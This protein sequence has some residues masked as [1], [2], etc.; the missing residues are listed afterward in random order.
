VPVWTRARRALLIA[1]TIWLVLGW[2]AFL[3]IDLFD[4]GGS[5]ALIAGLEQPQTYFHLYGEA[6]PTEWLQWACLGF[7]AVAAGV[8]AGRLLERHP[9]AGVTWA[10]FAAGMAVLLIEDAGNP[11][12]RVA[13]YGERLAGPAAG[14]VA[15]LA[16]YALVA[17]LPVLAAIR[18]R[19]YLLRFAPGHRYLLAGYAAYAVAAGASATRSLWY[20]RAGD[21]LF[22]DRLLPLT[23]EGVDRSSFFALDHLVEESVELV[24]AALLLAGALTA[25]EHLL[26]PAARHA[27]ATRVDLVGARRTVDEGGNF[28]RG[29]RTGDR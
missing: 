15:E 27:E 22:G 10:V 1:V 28:G 29:P 8:V 23:H 2:A 26:A 11:R 20:E 4:L 25:L 17:L 21:A 12:L 9:T 19:G 6:R 13:E 5:R 24:G 3:A 18:S 14:L 16:V 7:G